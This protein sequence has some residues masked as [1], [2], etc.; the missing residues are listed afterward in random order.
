MKKIVVITGGNSGIGEAT[1]FR[2]AQEGYH[3]VICARREN[4]NIKVV[5]QVRMMGGSAE[6]FIVDLRSTDAINTLFDDITAR[7]SRIDSL[8]NCAGIEGV[9]FV[10]F[11]A[12]PDAVFDDVMAVNVKAPWLCMKRVL[13]LMRKQR[14]GTIV[15]VASLAGLRSSVT[16]GVGYTASKHALVGI[17]KSAAKEYAAYQVRV[18][19]VCPAF[20]R[21]PMAQAVVGSDIDHYGQTHP[22]GRVCEKNEVADVIYWLCSDQSSFVTGTAIPVDGGVLA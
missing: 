15:N 5:Q 3:V 22:I 20:V 1:A 8:V 16:G 11:E 4:L 6:Q 2:F 7:H 19:A 17:T 14:S 9:A 21:T 18:N 10:G 13:S 12:Y